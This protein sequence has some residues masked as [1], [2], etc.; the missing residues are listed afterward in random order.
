MFSYAH[1]QM[2]KKQRTLVKK[3]VSNLIPTS[4]DQSNIFNL[5]IGKPLA[6]PA[7]NVQADNN[8]LKRIEDSL[9]AV[10]DKSR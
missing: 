8:A 9:V 5:F 1:T 6:V 2:K 3:D 4:L 7:E 10:E